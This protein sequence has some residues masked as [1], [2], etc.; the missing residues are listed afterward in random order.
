VEAILAW[1]APS[2]VK[3]VRSF[4]GFAN[5]YRRFIKGFSEIIRPLSDLTHKDQVF[6]WTRD[7]SESFERLKKMFSTG[8]LLAQFDSDLA[9]VLETDS[10][11]WCVGGVLM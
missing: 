7:A 4:L 5:F 10:S 9:T 1:E 6:K 8:P 3:G 2:N 11:G